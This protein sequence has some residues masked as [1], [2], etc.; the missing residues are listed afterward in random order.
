MDKR[1]PQCT[2][3]RMKMIEIRLLSF[4]MTM[5]LSIYGPLGDFSDSH[6]PK[7]TTEN[8]KTQLKM[9]G[10]NSKRK[11]KHHLFKRVIWEPIFSFIS[12]SI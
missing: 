7:D 10:H 11:S 9:K 4:I 3:L 6:H 1:L 5:N 12:F 8:E 2:I